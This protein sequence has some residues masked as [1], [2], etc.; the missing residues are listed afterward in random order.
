MTEP[1]IAAPRID[2][3]RVEA[4][5]YLKDLGEGALVEVRPAR[6]R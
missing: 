3:D 1:R 5:L 6:K 4:Y 2:L